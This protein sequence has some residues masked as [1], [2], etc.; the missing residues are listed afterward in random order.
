M[1]THSSV[2]A[3]RIPGTGHPGGLPSMGSHRVGHDRSDS[4]AAAAPFYRKGKWRY[5]NDQ[6]TCPRITQLVSRRARLGFPDHSVG[7]E[8]ICNARDPSSI[9]G[10]G[11]SPGEGKGY[12]F[13]YSGVENYS[14]WGR[15]VSDTTEQ[16]SLT[17]RIQTLTE[18]W[19]VLQLMI[20]TGSSVPTHPDLP[21]A[22]LDL[23]LEASGL[24]KAPQIWANQDSWSL[25]PVLTF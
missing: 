20:L 5:Q 6:V 23:V 18:P 13:H 9:P 11:R 7:K 4:A 19:K 2:L 22:I 14:P 15:K 21:G 3:W 12:P 8:S 1:A 17:H 25:Y 24:W 16:L 10:S